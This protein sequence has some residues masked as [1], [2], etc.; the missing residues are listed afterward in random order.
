MFKNFILILLVVFI[1]GCSVAGKP[2]TN[3]TNSKD[4]EQTLTSVTSALAGKPVSEQ[5]LRKLEKDLRNDPE[6]RSAVNEVANSFNG[7][8]KVKYCPVDG[9]RFAPNIIECPI[10]HVPLK[11]V[12]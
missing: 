8:V 9:K 2:T 4:A 6:A 3:A 5:D 10:H 11:W 12:E 1:C 7:E